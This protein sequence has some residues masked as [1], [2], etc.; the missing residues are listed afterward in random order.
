MTALWAVLGKPTVI[1]LSHN[2][3]DPIDFAALYADGVRMVI[4]KATQG[5]D[6]ADPLYAPRRKAALAAGMRWEAY[7]FC[8]N[9][10]VAEQLAHFLAVADL[11]ETMR[12]AIDAEPNRGATISFANAA[13]L[14][15]ATDQKRGTQALRYG[16]LAFADYK[17]PAWH[18]GPLWWA[19]Y[20][21]SP[22]ARQMRL[23]GV[24]VQNVVLW[25]ETG[26]GAR[27]GVHG[28]LDE[29]YFLRGDAALAGYPLLTGFPLTRPA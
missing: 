7:H 4:H 3:R 5:K 24:P 1:D 21:P 16:G 13:A 11:D 28:A 14:A 22:T 19:K 25:Q 20:G 26:S 18:N 6:Y 8:D 2:N 29:S 9:T 17:I 23:W 27:P 15:V 10:P 12:G